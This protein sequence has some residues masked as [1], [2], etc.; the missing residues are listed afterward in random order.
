[1][2]ILF[3]K[4]VC[5]LTGASG[6][7]GE[8]I[9]KQ[10]ASLGVSLI[11]TGRNT[12]KLGK[13]V[14]AL[15]GQHTVVCA[16][17]TQTEDMEKVVALCRDKSVSMLINNAGITEIGAFT[18]ASKG[19]VESVITTNLVVPITLT[20]KLIPILQRAP[21]AHIINIGSTFG[22]IGFACHSLYCAS[23]FGLRGW[24]ESLIREYAET[25][26]HFHYFAPRATQTSINT[27]Q[28]TSMN[29]ALGNTMDAPVDV[30]R[31]LLDMLYKKQSRRFLGFPEKWFV[32]INGA[33]P[34]IVDAALKKQLPT[35]QRYMK[36]PHEEKLS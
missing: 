25:N 24:T 13:L 31:A 36:A 26:L 1:M 11:L 22:S 14:E 12:G 2:A 16:D 33:F 15:P 21:D 35:I 17:L 3:E 29:K 18:D 32:K 23:K 6:G 10:L 28:A 5:L 7:I 8:A 4:Q 20:Q 27:A 19:A 9:A 30:A 34:R